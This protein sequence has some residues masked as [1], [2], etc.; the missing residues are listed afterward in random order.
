MP[1]PLD[2]LTAALAGRYR[3]ER[4]LGSGGMATVYLA[5]DL[6]HHRQVALKVLRPELA[7]VLGPERFLREIEIS[8][9]LH[10]PHV[11]PLYDSGE[12]EG[13]LYYVMPYVEG[14]SLR[15]RLHRE[16]QLAVDAAVQIAREVADALSYAHSQDVVHRDVKPENILLESGHAVVADFGIARA[17]DAAGGEKLTATGVAVGTPEYM[18]PEQASG[19]RQLDGR[20]DVYALGCVLYE[21]LAGH[22][23]FTGVTAREVLARHSLDAVPSLR[24]ARDAVSGELVRTVERALAKAPADRFRDAAAFATALQGVTSAGAGSGERSFGIPW[25]RKAALLT[26]ALA[27]VAVL[28]VLV[29]RSRSGSHAPVHSLSSVAVLPFTNQTGDSA[30]GYFV[31]GMHSGVIG[32]LAKASALLVKS[33]RS[34][35]R[36]RDSQ[37]SMSQIGAELGVGTL[38][39]AEVTRIGDSVGLEVHLVQAHPER[40]FWS[41]R[42]EAPAAEVYHMYGAIADSVVRHVLPG[43]VAQ[44]RAP[45]GPPASV[46]P[47][48][49]QAFLR[50]EQAGITDFLFAL[51]VDTRKAIAAFE[52]AVELDPR[53]AE[54]HAR[55]AIAYATLAFNDPTSEQKRLTAM[56]QVHADRALRLDSTS[57]LAYVALARHAQLVSGDLR[58]GVPYLL[59]ARELGPGSDEVLVELLFVYLT[60]CD[61]ARDVQFGTTA[62]QLNPFNSSATLLTGNGYWGTLKALLMASFEDPVHFDAARAQAA[63]DSAAWYLNRTI[64]LS[65]DDAQNYMYFAYWYLAEGDLR[66]ASDVLQRAQRTIGTERTTAAM[67]RSAPQASRILA[68]DGWYRALVE[69]ADLGSPNFDSTY[70]YAHKAMLYDG[71]GNTTRA[72]AYWDSVR[73][74][75]QPKS[76]RG[77]FDL[78]PWQLATAYASLGE[79]K[80]AVDLGNQLR[81]MAATR[82][83]SDYYLGLVEAAAG[84]EDATVAR[85]E[86]VVLRQPIAFVT[87]KFLSLD[88]GLRALRA[89]PRFRKLLAAY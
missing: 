72:R 28:A 51:N 1:E 54:A 73:A 3:V 67:L 60:D 42:F 61:Y 11:L 82:C 76:V 15:D 74:T 17:I 44:P 16:K 79:P 38:V 20:S 37:K 62:F 43:S 5:E 34:V 24:A 25:G 31:D 85:L 35:T 57:A 71:V 83:W 63:R 86:D 56:A 88:P 14:E 49:Y 30:L 33:A 23:P 2:R 87:P 40:E 41:Q 55:L 69:R 13:F 65:P 80:R 29:A 89:N 70:Y 4:Q 18:S 48:A 64:E 32:Q 47:A 77:P 22:P 58:R 68:Q 39:E 59:R 27:L 78:W 36:Y 53:F 75:A 81:G 9:R 6:K 50:G 52:R 8:A 7:A 66:G 45:R 12:A 21:M 84:L 26:G 46:D 19:Q 10:H